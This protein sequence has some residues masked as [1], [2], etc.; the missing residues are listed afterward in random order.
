MATDMSL[1]F[2]SLLSYFK[3]RE[4]DCEKPVRDSHL[5]EISLKCCKDWRLLPSQLALEDIVVND[6]DRKT[7]DEK[8]KR[9]DFF[10]EWRQKKGR[11]ATYEK[12]ILA[13][14]KLE[15]QRDAEKVCELL[16]QSL[17][18]STTATPAQS[19]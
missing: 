17:Q 4:E 9:R 18:A 19:M 14:L 6:I 1:E 3:L 12:L 2:S 15:Q 8:E 10:R 5:D 13:S 11:K 7:C 16:Q